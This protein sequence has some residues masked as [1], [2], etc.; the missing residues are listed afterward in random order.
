MP[1]DINPRL[2]GIIMRT[3]NIFRVIFPFHLNTHCIWRGPKLKRHNNPININDHCPATD[4][5]SFSFP[6]PHVEIHKTEIISIQ[7]ACMFDTSFRLAL[8]LVKE[9]KQ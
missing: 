5:Y 7:C 4:I 8:D 3:L 1:I 9:Q 6:Q 2:F